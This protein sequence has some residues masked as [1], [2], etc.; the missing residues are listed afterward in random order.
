MCLVN[1]TQHLFQV[2]TWLLQ[3]TRERL[4]LLNSGDMDQ[5]AHQ[6]AFL[7]MHSIKSTKRDKTR[8]EGENKVRYENQIKEMYLFTSMK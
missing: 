2:S 6:A 3:K 7:P 1:Q 8:E 4:H 5:K